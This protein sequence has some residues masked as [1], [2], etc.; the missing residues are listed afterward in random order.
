[1]AATVNAEPDIELVRKYEQSALDV[2]DKFRSANT[3]STA[4]SII[5]DFSEPVLV[6]DEITTSAILHEQSDI[7]PWPWSSVDITGS[8]K[9]SRL[10]AAL[11]IH[12]PPDV[13]PMSLYDAIPTEERLKDDNFISASELRRISPNH[14]QNCWSDNTQTHGTVT[15]CTPSQTSQDP[16]S[17]PVSSAGSYILLNRGTKVKPSPFDELYPFPSSQ[18]EPYP[19]PTPNT[20]NPQYIINSKVATHNINYLQEQA[21]HYGNTLAKL[22]RMLPEDDTKIVDLK[23]RL[24]GTHF[25]LGQYPVAAKWWNQV[26]SARSRKEGPDSVRVLAPSIQ[27]MKALF[28]TGKIDEAQRLHQQIHP[29]II[30]NVK[31]D[32]VLILETLYLMAFFLEARSLYTE[33]DQIWRQQ[34]QIGLT[35]RG[36]KHPATLKIMDR[37]AGTLVHRESTKEEH[38]VIRKQEAEISQHLLWVSLQLHRDAEPGVEPISGENR[39]MEKYIIRNITP[40]ADLVRALR[41]SGRYDESEQLARS[42]LDRLKAFLGRDHPATLNFAAELGV[43]L[44]ENNKLDESERMLQETL[45]LRSKRLG[46]RHIGTLN[47]MDELASTLVRSGKLQEASRLLE[48]VMLIRLEDWGPTFIDTIKNCKSLQECCIMQGELGV[49][50]RHC[51]DMI[52][53]IRKSKGDD[54]PTIAEVQEWIQN[55]NDLASRNVQEWEAYDTFT[56]FTQDIASRDR[57]EHPDIYV[58]D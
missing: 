28:N 53:L 33:A 46:E 36:P 25:D 34:L 54:Y 48:E 17:Q 19:F 41:V 42:V 23:E 56:D 39:T 5:L 21:N 30:Q 32:S 50:L 15:K 12:Y 44:R 2:N 26:I 43:T 10:F 22:E 47:S 18:E 31:M 45:R 7:D 58:A 6:N 11:A 38:H 20:L 49:A 29:I 27:L 13:E 24:G 55:I 1:M 35:T 16:R 4:S 57:N 37:M 14:D 3:P 9:L 40:V 8:P 52:D 51:E